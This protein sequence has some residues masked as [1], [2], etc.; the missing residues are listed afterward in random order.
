MAA[1]MIGEDSCMR[2]FDVPLNRQGRSYRIDLSG[3]TVTITLFREGSETG[4]SLAA[5][6]E[7]KSPVSV[8]VLEGPSALFV[9]CTGL[10]D[11]RCRNCPCHKQLLQG[12][13]SIVAQKGLVFRKRIDCLLEPA[14][15][16]KTLTCLNCISRERGSS[17]FTTPMGRDA[18]AEYLDTG[19]NALSR[20][21][22]RVKVDGI[23]DRYKNQFRFTKSQ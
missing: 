11:S 14:V 7:Y 2:Y 19:R 1:T 17:S 5:G 16:E 23:L 3:H 12:S 4:V 18:M 21:L 10:T 9:S 22:S 8:G 20:G 13:M 15:R 6:R